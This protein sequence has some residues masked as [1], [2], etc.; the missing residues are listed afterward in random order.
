MDKKSENEV[1]SLETRLAAV[2][3]RKA[4]RQ[5]EID[6]VR[7]MLEAEQKWRNSWIWG[8]LY[9]V[10]LLALMGGIL[11]ILHGGMNLINGPI[12]IVGG[13]TSYDWH[14]SDK[15]IKLLVERLR[16]LRE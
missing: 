15:R 14:Q 2:A 7:A 4:Q 1:D 5:V 8:A 16:K 12:V 9:G 6:S 11:N 13:L 3:A 10:G